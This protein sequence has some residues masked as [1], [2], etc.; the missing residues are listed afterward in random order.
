MWLGLSRREEWIRLVGGAIVAV[1]AYSL[2]SIQIE[3]APRGY[4]TLLNGRAAA[5][6]FTV[7]ML[8]ALAA[9]HVRIGKHLSQLSANVALLTTAAS[10]FTLSLLTS[11]VDAFWA[12]RGAAAAWSITREGLQAIVWAS[13]GGFLIWQGLS[14][15]RTWI[16]A[17]GGGLLGVAI[18]RLLR[19]QF[20]DP[21][22][23]YIVAANARVVAAVIVIAM[24]Y[25]L[26]RLYQDAGDAIEAGFGPRTILLLIANVLTLTLL[27]SEITAY[28]RMHDARPVSASASANS[29][30]AREMMLSITWAAY[31]TLLVVVGLMKRYAPIRYFAMTVFVMTIVKVFAIDLAEL[32]RIYRVLSVVGLGVMLLTSSYLYQRFHNSADV[33]P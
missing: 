4:V 9:L 11:E 26:A 25:G 2:L 19:A 23:A 5:G 27:T 17:I 16:R 3:T 28:W 14:N 30:F 7:V 21:S 22:P 1:G 10:L 12:S 31:A 29:H 6:G 24:L 20:A 8:C 32:D 18:V 33:A 15:H 13:V